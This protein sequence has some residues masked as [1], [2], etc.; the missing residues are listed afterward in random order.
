MRKLEML[1]DAHVQEIFY[2]HFGPMEDAGNGMVRIVRCIERHG[3]LV[4][5]ISTVCPALAALKLSKDVNEF[6]RRILREHS[7]AAH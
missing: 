1:D 4:P 3:V 6:T 5:V 7:E 2:T